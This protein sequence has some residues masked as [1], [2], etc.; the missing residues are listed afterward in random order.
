VAESAL[1]AVLS[2]GVDVC[3]L[4]LWSVPLRDV[5]LLRSDSEPPTPPQAVIMRSYSNV[6]D[7]LN[8]LRK[9]G[10][11]KGAPTSPGGYGKPGAP[12]TTDRAPVVA[13]DSQASMADGRWCCGPPL[14]LPFVVGERPRSASVANAAARGL[15]A[16]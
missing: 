3:R 4:R 13:A 6:E 2:G 16:E 11:G 1:V 9:N 7:G 8:G 5:C 10:G 15:N 14:P 12:P